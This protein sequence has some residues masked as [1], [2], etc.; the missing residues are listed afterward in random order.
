M[1]AKSLQSCPTL[2]DLMDRSTP[3]FPVLYY[4]PEFAQV[5]VHWVSDAMQPSHP[6]PLLLLFPSIFPIIRVFSNELALCIRWWPK[7]WSFSISP[8]NEY[9]ELISF[10]IGWFSLQSQG[11]SKS[12]PALNFESINS[13]VLSLF[14]GPALTS[15]HDYWKNHCFDYID[16]C[17]VMSAF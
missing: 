12:S 3:G 15:T 16:H 6:L 14:Y 2:C 17:L 5:H 4:L 7:Y 8:S 11:P 1:C 10:K 13:S 9:S